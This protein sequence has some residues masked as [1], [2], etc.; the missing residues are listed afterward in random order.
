M[1][2]YWTTVMLVVNF[3][4]NSLMFCLCIK[5]IKTIKL[6]C[7]H[8]IF[9]ELMGLEERKSKSAHYKGIWSPRTHNPQ[10]CNAWRPGRNLQYTAETKSQHCSN[11]QVWV[12]GLQGTLHMPSRTTS[13]T[14][15]CLPN[16][17]SL[18][19]S[20]LT[21]TSITSI[22]SSLASYAWSNPER[23]RDSRVTV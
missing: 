1:K 20:I 14:L 21:F 3:S 9:C 19:W 4:A 15:C 11:P 18:P 7:S 10:V 2:Y 13:R 17:R 5:N 16:S 23:L 22:V 12:F 6:Q 8:C